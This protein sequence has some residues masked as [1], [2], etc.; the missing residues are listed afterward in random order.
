MLCKRC[1]LLPLPSGTIDIL[2]FL[3]VSNHANHVNMSLLLVA[4]FRCGD[5]NSSAGEVRMLK[6]IEHKINTENQAS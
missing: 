5:E 4:D 3:M 6:V 1:C 2:S